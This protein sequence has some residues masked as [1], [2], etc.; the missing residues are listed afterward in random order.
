MEGKAVLAG[1]EGAVL[2]PHAEDKISKVKI[3]LE[4]NGS[5]ECDYIIS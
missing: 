4:F 1:A 2:T 5:S 3:I